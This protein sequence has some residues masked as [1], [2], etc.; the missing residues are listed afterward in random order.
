MDEKE[1]RQVIEETKNKYRKETI[2][3]NPQYNSPISGC[4]ISKFGGSP[5]ISEMDS[6][7]CCDICRTPLNFVL[8]LFKSD[9]PEFYFPENKDLF[10][11]F[12]CPNEDCSYMEDN[13]EESD[14]KMFVFYSNSKSEYQKEID[15]PHF[16]EDG[17]FEDPVPECL[18]SP[19]KV[20]DYPIGEYLEYED[21]DFPSIHD[22]GNEVLSELI[23]EISPVVGSKLGGYPSYLQGSPDVECECGKEMDFLI[24]ISGEEPEKIDGNWSPHGLMIGDLGN[25]YWFL[26]PDCKS[27]KSTWDCG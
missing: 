15:P 10:Q 7:P 14:R 20:V 12:R 11:I 27:I 26:C 23:N 24:Q 1:A 21:P 16:P 8:Q 4:D 19:K 3:L 18:L 17:D 13:C 6:W 2:L 9:F 5:M 25:I 22:D